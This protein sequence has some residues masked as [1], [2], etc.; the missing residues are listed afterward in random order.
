LDK[1]IRDSQHGQTTGIPIGPDTSFIIAEILLARCDQALQAKQGQLTGIRW[2]DEFELLVAGRGEAD[3]LLANLQQVL[4]EFELRV[5]PRKTSISELPVEF[6]PDW[7]AEF[8]RFTFRTPAIGQA[9][10]L[11]RYFDRI[12]HYLGKRPNEHVVKYALARIRTLKAH[13]ANSALFQSLVCQA[14]TFEPGAVREAVQIL[15]Y[16]EAHHGLV[17]NRSLL[18]LTINRV[19]KLSAQVGYDYEV[20][21]CLWA[22]IKW[23]LP[24]EQEVAVQISALSNSIIAILALDADNLGLFGGRLNLQAWQ[25]RMTQDELYGEEWLLAYEA[26]IQNWLPSVGGG[27][28]VQ[29]DNAFALLK[30]NGVSFYQRASSPFTPGA[31]AYP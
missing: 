23:S 4:A 11:I 29:S 17:V 13:P 1:L 30:R 21:W 9:N 27:D 18:E 3:H 16:S 24:L 31:L 28:H 25:A 2:I 22:A 20:S 26:N 15:A 10:D 5:N 12:T 8:R 14:A 7:I 19:A 6:E